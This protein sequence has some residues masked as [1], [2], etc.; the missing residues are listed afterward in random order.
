MLLD[1]FEG[2]DKIIGMVYSNTIKLPEGSY[3]FY[4]Y[5][6]DELN[7]H[8]KIPDNSTASFD[9]PGVIVVSAKSSQGGFDLL[10]DESFLTL[11]ILLIFLLIILAGIA[12]IVR[13][14]RRIL[15]HNRDLIESA[16][17]HKD[18][19]IRKTHEKLRGHEDKISE[20]LKNISDKLSEFEVDPEHVIIDMSDEDLDDEDRLD[21]SELLQ[22]GETELE[23]DDELDVELIEDIDL[24]DDLEP[25]S[26]SE[27]I[28]DEAPVPDVESAEPE[29]EDILENEVLSDDAKD[30]FDHMDL[31]EM[32]RPIEDLMLCPQCGEI[33]DESYTSCPGCGVNFSFK[34]GENIDEGSGT[35]D[36]PTIPEDVEEYLDSEPEA[37]EQPENDEDPI[38][39][40]D[41]NNDIIDDEE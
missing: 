15:K 7:E 21:G 35:T 19:H 8:A 6:R 37:L 28:D 24:P 2:N 29:T 4:F 39:S 17:E 20:E 10:R 30:A 3:P 22:L 32:E 14:R 40:S 18:E 5:G 27:P 1:H 41:D 34:D 13:Y 16:K 11:F 23:S 33:V 25:V 9:E 31:N 12:A 26:D 36:K 38:K